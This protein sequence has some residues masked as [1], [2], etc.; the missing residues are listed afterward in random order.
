MHATP[1]QSAAWLRFRMG[2][3]GIDSLE[4]LAELCGSDKGNLS[5]IFRQQQRPRVDALEPLAAGLDVS[6]YELLVRIGA[7]D[8]DD[9]TP[10]VVA[11]RGQTLRFTWPKR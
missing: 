9:D 8:P 1:E 4:A 10:P 6:V 5:R 7:V 3:L 2:E 11:K